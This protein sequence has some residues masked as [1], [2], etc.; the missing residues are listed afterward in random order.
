MKIF[1]VCKFVGIEEDDILLRIKI[2][3][4]K[5]LVD[6]WI[7]LMNKRRW[8]G[9]LVENVSYESI[10]SRDFYKEYRER[11]TCIKIDVSPWDGN[12]PIWDIGL[13]TFCKKGD[14]KSDYF[15]YK[16]LAAQYDT[17]DLR[18]HME[19]FMISAA[20]HHSSYAYKYLADIAKDKD[21][22]LISDLDESIDTSNREK[23]NMIEL[24]VKQISRQET[25][26]RILRHKFQYDYI[27]TWPSESYIPTQEK[28]TRWIHAVSW[29]LIRVYGR[30][31]FQ[32]F[33][34][35]GAELNLVNKDLSL[36]FEYTLCCSIEEIKNKY[37]YN[38]HVNKISELDILT[39]LKLNK[40]CVD[41]SKLTQ[42]EI[43]HKLD[44]AMSFE[45]LWNLDERRSSAYVLNNLNKLSTNNVAIDYQRCRNQLKRMIDR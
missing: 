22:V 30:Y 2:E 16:K 7:L 14:Q 38:G 32:D 18:R 15:H 5:N 26:G 17:K 43:L 28:G 39:A 33:R 8:N 9:D 21:I 23:K 45:M 25:F 31:A 34:S 42:K 13:K 29:K 19:R 20:R 44:Q 36:A 4:E 40:M 1:S 11:I 27:N 37:K 41:S 3:N 24:F 6:K 12:Y 10:I 35:Y